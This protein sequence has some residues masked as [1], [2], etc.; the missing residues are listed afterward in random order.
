MRVKKE[1]DC[2]EN[3]LV[4]QGGGS[5]GAYECGVYKTISKLGIKIDVVAGTSIGGINSSIIAASKSNDPA[6]DLEDFWLTLAQTVTP[7]FLTD[8]A[9]EISS[10]IYSAMWGNSN[11][12]IPL[13]LRP[14]FGFFYNSPYLYD[15]SPLKTTLEKFVDYTK[16]KDP[17]RPR[18]VITSTDIQNGKP[19]IFDSKYDT[20]TSDHVL[21]SA[22]YPFYGISW[23]KVGNKYLWDGTLLS[24][25]PLREVIDA[26]PTCDKRVIIANLFPRGQ[27]DIPKNMLESWHR[28]RDIM[29]TDKTDQTVRMSKV[30]SRY[31][32]IINK[33]HDILESIPL[34]DANR[35]KL[36][37]IE[38]EFNK[39]ACQRGAII[40][41]IVR[42]ERRED[43]HY[44][45][46]D[47]DFSID[48]IKKLIKS[49]EEDA[50]KALENFGKN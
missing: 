19:S 31:L 3:V 23:T 21:S 29:H 25:T 40:K 16:L 6:K 36:A 34:D 22:G 1:R 37:E 27:E 33:M 7:S 32:T 14:T 38:P 30:V 17:S 50:K 18:L 11:A 41:E 35:K 20:F 42:I 45:F 47:A 13:W 9:R 2:E 5:L 8:R 39:L 24:N 15:M 12:F 43:S 46:E 4:L 28:A 26:S 10:S 44:L 48:T 49:G